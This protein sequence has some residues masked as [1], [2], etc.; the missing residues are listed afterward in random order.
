M[1]DVYRDAEPPADDTYVTPIVVRPAPPASRADPSRLPSP[2]RVPTLI[3]KNGAVLYGKEPA[4]GSL[5][6]ARRST[7]VF[8]I[9]P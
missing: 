6:Q 9:R 1:V 2:S 8:R 4:Q 5:A 3:A 7:W